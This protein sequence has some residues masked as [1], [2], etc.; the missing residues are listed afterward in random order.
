VPD[1]QATPS[2]TIT[3]MV[4]LLFSGVAGSADRARTKDHRD[5]AG[6][7]QSAARQYRAA[8]SERR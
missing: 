3:R 5:P 1:C 2:V 6:R 7:M 4:G 8:V